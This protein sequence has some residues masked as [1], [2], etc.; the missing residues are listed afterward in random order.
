MVSWE[1]WISDTEMFRLQ[2]SAPRRSRRGASLRVPPRGA[3]TIPGEES[4]DAP[5]PASFPGEEVPDLQG[6][7]YLEFLKLISLVSRG[8]KPDG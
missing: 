4:G 3:G 7:F 5:S 6:C 2:I 1:G 8:K